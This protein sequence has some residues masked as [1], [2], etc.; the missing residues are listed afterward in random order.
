MELNGRRQL[1]SIPNY[2]SC[3]CFKLPFPPPQPKSPIRSE[4]SPFHPKC[5]ETKV[6]E[7]FDHVKTGT[8]MG[9]NVTFLDEDAST[10]RAEDGTCGVAK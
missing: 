4:R 6:I 1:S 7:L 2:E 5:K 3:Y 10:D 8:W 9:Q